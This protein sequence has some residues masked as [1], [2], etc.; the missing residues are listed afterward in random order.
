LEGCASF[1]DEGCLKVVMVGLEEVQVVGCCLFRYVEL[2]AACCWLGLLPV[3]DK[4]DC[5]DNGICGWSWS[6]EG[7]ERGE[8]VV[9][10]YEVFVLV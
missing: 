7:R 1:G 9:L 3:G 6:V 5:L 4:S 2:E 8:I 10:T